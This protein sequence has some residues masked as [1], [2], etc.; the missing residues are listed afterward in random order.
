M[1][2]SPTSEPPENAEEA[3]NETAAQ[4]GELE[5]R[6]QRPANKQYF[7]VLEFSARTNGWVS[8]PS[9]YSVNV[10]TQSASE[11]TGQFHA[12][13][14]HAERCPPEFELCEFCRACPCRSCSCRTGLRNNVETGVVHTHRGNNQQQQPETDQQPEGGSCVQIN[15]E[16]SERGEIFMPNGA[17]PMRLPEYGA[18]T[19]NGEWHGEQSR[20]DPHSGKRFIHSLRTRPNLIYTFGVFDTLVI[21]SLKTNICKNCE[22]CL[23]I[24]KKLLTNSI[25]TIEGIL[26]FIISISKYNKVNAHIHRNFELFS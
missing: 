21:I 6:G 24:V 13:G 5:R 9:A 3:I 4:A 18:G 11:R 16:G 15:Q 8:R 20:S 14:Y 1:L 26:K 25:V 12:Y 22:S 19:A 2:V 10:E 23:F 7:R 17:V